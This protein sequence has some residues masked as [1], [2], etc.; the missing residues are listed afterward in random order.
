MNLEETLKTSRMWKCHPLNPSSAPTRETQL[1]ALLFKNWNMINILQKIF[2][3]K[4]MHFFR[5]SKVHL[6]RPSISMTATICQSG[7]PQQPICITLHN[8][9]RTKPC[10]N[11]MITQATK[12]WRCCPWAVQQVKLHHRERS[13]KPPQHLSQGISSLCKQQVDLCIFSVSIQ[14][15]QCGSATT[16]FKGILKKM[17]IIEWLALRQYT[18]KKCF[19]VKLWTQKHQ[20]TFFP[21]SLP[22][23]F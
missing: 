11:V 3:K 2:R 23:K 10:D 12:P 13:R 16:I 19:T 8:Y 20:V 22:C 14:K 7:C 6:K 18:G 21:F 15:S 17:Q 1:W 4:A 9:I 5:S